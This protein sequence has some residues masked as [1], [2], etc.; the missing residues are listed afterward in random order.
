V[1]VYRA[2]VKKSDPDP[3]VMLFEEVWSKNR[4]VGCNGA[5]EAK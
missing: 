3:L 4:D 2:Y 1:E 5:I